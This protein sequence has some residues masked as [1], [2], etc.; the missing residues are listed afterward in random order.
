[1]PQRN[2]FDAEEFTPP[3]KSFLQGRGGLGRIQKRFSDLPLVLDGEPDNLGLFDGPASGRTRGRDD[4]VRK[5]T[6]FDFRGALQ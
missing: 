4:K 3:P 1:L 2:T 5:G 6:P